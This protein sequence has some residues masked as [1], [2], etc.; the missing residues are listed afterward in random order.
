MEKVEQ[1]LLSEGAGSQTSSPTELN[2]IS[3]GLLN[4]HDFFWDKLDEPHLR[5]KYAILKAHPE[6]KE[7]FG[8][9]PNTKYK[10]FAFVGIQLFTCYMVTNYVHS[11]WLY[12][13][14]AYVIG[15]TF[16]HS[17]SIS[18]HEATHNLIFEKQMYNSLIAIFVNLP[19]TLPAAMSFKRYHHEHHLYQGVDVIDTD[20][21]TNFE[22]DR[23]RGPIGKA[24]FVTFMSLFY[25][26]RPLFTYPK[27]PTAWELF[28]TAV[29]F[30]FDALI[31]YLG[32]FKALGYLLLSTFLGLGLHPT[33]GHFIQEHFVFEEGQETYSYYGPLNY[34]ML[35]VGYHNEHHDFPRIPGSR[36]PLVKKIAPEYYDNLKYYTSWTKVIIDYIFTDGMTMY[37]R[38][39]RTKEMHDAA[40]RQNIMK[41]R[42][43]HDCAGSNDG[44]ESLKKE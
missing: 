14:I 41:G 38:T 39:K 2:E 26:L 40:R 36:L 31:F 1:A 6:I 23:L 18:I 33:A 5:R 43:E 17:C 11:W 29:Q 16:N 3:S 27:K 35:N 8:P 25:A 44:S 42:K 24:F 19:L 30:S 9:D 10:L 37:N 28:N 22:A 7:L 32:G 34:V 20:I 15:G 4:R 13:L 12:L 21:A